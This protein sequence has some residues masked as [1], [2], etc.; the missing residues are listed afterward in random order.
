MQHTVTKRIIVFDLFSGQQH[1]WCYRRGSLCAS[2]SHPYLTVL[3]QKGLMTCHQAHGGEVWVLVTG[4]RSP[5]TS[6]MPLFAIVGL[7]VGPPL[8]LTAL[9]GTVLAWRHWWLGCSP[10]QH[11]IN[12]L[13]VEQRADSAPAERACAPEWLKDACSTKLFMALQKKKIEHSKIF[14]G[15]QCRDLKHRTQT[16]DEMQEQCERCQPQRVAQ[17]RVQVE[18]RKSTSYQVWWKQR[19]VALWVCRFAACVVWCLSD[20]VFK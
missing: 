2:F 9:P 5:I 1:M 7:V 12:V 14:R 20:A 8:D 15:I 16:Y 6:R 11:K 3:K 18:K 13:T 4:N 10:C 17:T 19:C